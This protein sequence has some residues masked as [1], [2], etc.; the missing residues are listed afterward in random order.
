MSL[1]KLID[2]SKFINFN[3]ETIKSNFDL[4]D[5]SGIEESKIRN[6]AYEI[7]HYLIADQKDYKLKNL[8]RLENDNLYISDIDLKIDCKACVLGAIIMNRFDINSDY[9]Y[10]ELIND[11]F[12]KQKLIDNE[13][14][15]LTNEDLIKSGTITTL[16]KL[17]KDKK[18]LNKIR[19]SKNNLPKYFILPKFFNLSHKILKRTQQKEVSNLSSA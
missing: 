18:F 9:I 11:E 12:T 2:F 6:C 19:Y 14:I 3:Y 16:I 4:N 1:Q 8:G 5:S 13:I 10:R 17:P 15:N 7:A